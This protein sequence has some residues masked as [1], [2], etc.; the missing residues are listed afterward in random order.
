MKTYSIEFR[1]AVAA[2]HDRCG[3][4]RQV[5]GQF[6]CCESWVRRLIQRRRETGS[7][8][9][10]PPVFPDNRVL[11][12]A[13]RAALGNLVEQTCDATLAELAAALGDSVSI[14]TIWRAL[15][16]M[17]LSRKKKRGTPAS[18]IGPMSR[19]RGRTGRPKSP[20]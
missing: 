13:G 7:L 2:A 10:K 20:V 8:E 17:G 19:P 6:K 3:S 15:D 16:T 14:S 12:D 5:A 11:D 18:R 9:P 1:V 4:S